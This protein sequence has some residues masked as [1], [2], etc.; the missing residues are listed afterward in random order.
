MEMK[1]GTSAK[2]DNKKWQVSNSK[3]HLSY[4]MFELIRGHCMSVDQKRHA[5]HRE[6][7][8]VNK[9]N[10]CENNSYLCESLNQ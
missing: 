3:N 5:F 6:T 10:K 7:T 9:F 8:L 2:G 4:I 1:Y